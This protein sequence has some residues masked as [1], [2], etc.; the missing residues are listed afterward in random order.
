MLQPSTPLPQDSSTSPS[1]RHYTPS[2]AS[3]AEAAAADSSARE[4]RLQQGSRSH[5]EEQGAPQPAPTPLLSFEEAL[6]ACA[7]G[8]A[9]RQA[10]GSAAGTALYHSKLHHHVVSIKVR[11]GRKPQ[12]LGV[13]LGWCYAGLKCAQ[14]YL[15]L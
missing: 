9:A 15:L 6:A 10:A 7:R 1:R 8:Y 14:A 3:D 2:P 4:A 11:T 5:P 13:R 12:I